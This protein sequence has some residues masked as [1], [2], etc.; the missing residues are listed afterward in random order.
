[1][2]QEITFDRFVRGLLLLGALLIAYFLIN[3]LSGILLPFIVACFIAYL[4]YPL[5][6]FFQYKCRLR[7]RALSIVLAVAIFF[8]VIGGLLYISVP[9][10][11]SESLH[12]KDVAISYI[13]KGTENN[14]IP[15]PIQD[16]FRR[17]ANELQLDEL[18]KESNVQEAIKNAVPK[19]WQFASSTAGTILSI[20]S[21]LIG[22]LYLFLILMD[23][24]RYALGWI[25][26][27][28]PK[29]RP[30]ARRLV[31]DVRINMTGYFRG[32]ML[33]ALSNC[34]LFSIGFLI[35]GFPL[36]FGLGIF[37][38][39]I[40]FIPYIQVLGI[41]PAAILALLQAAETGQNFFLLLG[42]VLLVYIVVQIIQDVI[43]TPKIMGKIMGLKPAVILLSL[44]V[45][46]YLLGIIGL[47]IALPVTTLMLAYYKELIVEGNPFVR[48]AANES[49]LDPAENSLSSSD[50]E[51]LS[52]S[53][54]L[55]S[56]SEAEK[57]EENIL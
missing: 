44:S 27:I 29:R 4:L 28:P 16:F 49:P 53:E 25:N 12:L 11:I 48:P 8:G 3:E 31:N 15:Q 21:S 2:R 38:G 35:I 54:S 41:V 23:Y 9:A 7:S 19:V 52:A 17:H 1:M 45:W 18:L 30:F 24:E 22:V 57:S 32:Q 13:E 26:Y 50:E 5:V 39:L 43:V 40:S 51:A 47:I 6:C 56:L 46:G 37:I 20:L 10:L 34:V 36:P 14:T 55:S 33:V 42:G